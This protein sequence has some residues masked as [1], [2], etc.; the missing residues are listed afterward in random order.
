MHLTSSRCSLSTGWMLQE[1]QCNQKLHSNLEGWSI[2]AQYGRF[3]PGVVQV[4]VWRQLDV[5]CSR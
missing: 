2:A 5:D 3:V 4:T 1:T